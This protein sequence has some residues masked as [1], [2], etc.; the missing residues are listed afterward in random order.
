MR[1]QEG[2]CVLVALC[3]TCQDLV[4]CYFYFV[5]LPLGPELCYVLC[6]ILVICALLCWCICLSCV[7]RVCELFGE[8]I[9]NVF[10][11]GCYFVAECYGRV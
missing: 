4:S 1:V 11:C 8:T 7:L 9:R 6:Y 3:L 2:L 10:G 5:L